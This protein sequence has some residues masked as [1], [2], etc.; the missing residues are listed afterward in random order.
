VEGILV[1]GG[2]CVASEVQRLDATKALLETTRAQL[3]ELQKQLLNAGS[4]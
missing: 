2:Y 3:D 4:K 1:K